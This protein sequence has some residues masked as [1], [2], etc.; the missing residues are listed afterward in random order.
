MDSDS[1]SSHVS[2]EVIQEM[3]ADLG[4]DTPLFNLET[5]QSNRSCM[6]KAVNDLKSLKTVMES[7]LNDDFNINNINCICDNIVRCYNYVGLTQIDSLQPIRLWLTDTFYRI[8]HELLFK[9]TCKSFNLDSGKSD[10]KFSE[11]GIDS[12]RTPDLII[13]LDDKSLLVLEVSATSNYDK[14]AQNK[15]VEEAGF[16]SKYI[17]ELNKLKSNGKVVH[18]VPLIFDMSE[19]T[20]Y[21]EPQLKKLKEL[22]KLNL[23]ALATTRV[24]YHELAVITN[25]TKELNYLPSAILFSNTLEIK[26]DHDRLKFLY[27]NDIDDRELHEYIENKISH[28]VYKRISNLW[29]R[30]PNIIDQAELDY[31]VRY[32]PVLSISNGRLNFKESDK[33]L[34]TIEFKDIL[35][36]NDKPSFFSALKLDTG[37]AIIP[38]DTSTTGF[39]MTTRVKR[40]AMSTLKK[41][42]FSELK[43]GVD[44]TASSVPSSSQEVELSFL[45]KYRHKLDTYNSYI[46]NPKMLEH[47]YEDLLFEKIKSADY[48]YLKDKDLSK[49][50]YNIEIKSD[51]IYNK[52]LK[53]VDI[54]SCMQDVINNML[55][56]NEVT[57]QLPIKRFRVKPAFLLPL[58]EVNGNSYCELSFKNT[59][60]INNIINFLYS[61]DLFTTEILRRSLGSNYH[62]YKPKSSPSQHL[63]NLMAQRAKLNMEICRIYRVGVRSLTSKEERRSYKVTNDPTFPKVRGELSDLDKRIRILKKEEGVTE[64][65]S[66]IRLP[67][68]NRKTEV[69]GWFNNEMSHFKRKDMQSTIEGVGFSSSMSKM[70]EDGRETLN[71]IM[72]YL[73]EY[74]GENKDLVYLD[75]SQAADVPLLMQLKQHAHD[76][77]K[78]LINNVKDS[79]LGHAAALVSRMCHSLLFYSQLNFNAD[80]VRVDNLGYNNV[81]L[82][83]RGGNKIFKSKSSKLYRII[84]PVNKSVVPWMTG[85]GSTFQLFEYLGNNYIVTPWQLMHESI[86]TDGLSFY[87]RVV[88]FTVLNSK[89][90]LLLSEQFTR[91]AV[92]VLLS[93]HNRR[94]TEVFLANLRYVLFSCLGD[95]SGMVAIFNEF[96]GFNYDYF[97]G[98]LRSAFCLN[99]PIYFNQLR[100]IMD[101]KQ[102]RNITV[103]DLIFSNRIKNIF[104]NSNISS[105]DDMALMVYSTFLMTKAPYKRNV[106]RAGNLTGILD[107]HGYYDKEIGLTLNSVEQFNKIS[108]VCNPEDN[109]ETYTSKLFENDFNIDPKYISLMGVYA[110]SMLERKVNTDQISVEWIKIMSEC[111]DSMAT[112]TGLRGDLDDAVDFWGKKGYFVVYKDLIRNYNFLTEIQNLFKLGLTDDEKRKTIRHLNNT[113]LDKVKQKCEFWVFHAV[114]KTQ[115]RGGREIYVMDIHT[116]Q[117][118]QPIEKFMAYLCKLLDN[119]LISIPADKRSQVIHHSI[120]EKDVSLEGC[121]TWYLTLDCS[122]WAP[123]SSFVKFAIMILSMKTIPSSFKTHFLNYLDK[124]YVK[125]IYFNESEVDVLYKNNKYTALI[126]KYLIHDNN[127]KGYYMIMP[128]S[129][130]MGI[131]NYTS[132]FMHAVNQEYASYFITNSSMSNLQEETS[133]T[134]YAH[135][136]DSGGR[137]TAQYECLIK[138]ALF[139]YELQLKCCNHLLS[140]KKSVISRFY[141]EILSIIYIFKQLLAL[142]PKF[143]GGLRFLPT[144]KGPAQDMSQSYSKCIE[145]M[146]AGADFSTAFLVMNFYSA[147]IWRFYYNRAPIQSDF[148]RPVQFLG[149]PCAHPLMVLLSGADSD[150]VRLITSGKSE[151]IKRIL[152]LNNVLKSNMSQD[153]LLPGYKFNIKVRGIQ[154]GFEESLEM[155]SEQLKSWSIKYVNFKNTAFNFLGFLSKLTDPGFVGS[156]VNETTVRRLSRSFYMKSG[157]SVSTAYGNWSMSQLLAA[158]EVVQNHE[159]CDPLGLKDLFKERYEQFENDFYSVDEFAESQFKAIKLVLSGPIKICDYMSSLNLKTENI[160]VSKR[161]LK[162]THLQINKTGVGFS[163]HFDP[164]ILVS[165]ITDVGLRWALPD[166]RS[167]EFLE[168]ELTKLC[169]RFELNIFDLEPSF[170]LQ[171]CRFFSVKNIKDIYLYSRLPSDLKQI[172][173]YTGFLSFLAANSFSGRE[174]KGMV[175]KLDRDIVGADYLAKSIEEQVYNYATIISLLTILTRVMKKD[176]RHLTINPVKE[177]EWSGGTL[178]DFCCDLEN[179]PLIDPDFALLK[180]QNTYLREMLVFGHCRAESLMGC[181][182]YTFIKSQKSG[183][184]WHGQG[185]LY[186]NCPT[187]YFSFILNNNVILS[188]ET[189][190]YGKLD[191]LDLNYVLEV[192][193]SNGVKL[194]ARYFLNP[195]KVNTEEMFGYDWS[196]DIS[197]HKR[198]EMKSGVPAYMRSGRLG[199]M[200]NLSSYNVKFIDKNKYLLENKF[201]E[202]MRSYKIYTLN[203][204]K[205]LL[206]PMIKQMFNPNDFEEYLLMEGFGSLNEFIYN[207]V[208]SDFGTESYITIDTLADNFAST[209]LFSILQTAKNNSLAQIPKKISTTIFPAP[210]GGLLRMLYEYSVFRPDDKIIKLPKEINRDYMSIRSLFPEQFTAVLAETT[211]ANYNKLFSVKERNEI[212]EI[213]KELSQY[214]DMDSL[215]NRLIKTMS[216]WGYTSLTNVVQMYS[217]TK[218]KENFKS[219]KFESNNSYLSYHSE[220]FVVVWKILH[221]VLLEN[222][223]LIN[224]LELPIASLK[225]EKDLT[226]FLDDLN[227]TT[228]LAPYCYHY[229]AQCNTYNYLKF[230]NLLNA[231]LMEDSFVEGVINAFSRE[232][233]LATLPIDHKY[234]Y[235]LV[236][237]LNNLRHSWALNHKMVFELDFTIRTQRLPYEVMEPTTLYKELCVGEA[238]VTKKKPFYGQLDRSVVEF[239]KRDKRLENKDKSYFIK[240]QISKFGDKFPVIE[241]V[242]FKRNINMD[243]MDGNPDFE[244]LVYELEM[245]IL[246]LDTINEYIEMLGDELYH[247]STTFSEKTGNVT[248]VYCRLCVLT[249]FGRIGDL[250]WFN[251]LRQIGENIVIITDLYMPKLGNYFENCYTRVFNSDEIPGSTLSKELIAYGLM[252]KPILNNDLMDALFGKIRLN[253][254]HEVETIIGSNNYLNQDGSVGLFK[255]T[256]EH[257]LSLLKTSDQLREQEEREENEKKEREETKKMKKDYLND[258]KKKSLSST[259]NEAEQTGKINGVTK[260]ILYEK[261]RRAIS[262]ESNRALENILEDLFTEINLNKLQTIAPDLLKGNMSPEESLNV[263]QMPKHW[264]LAFENNKISKSMFSDK[265]VQIELSA[266]HTELPNY[267]G[268]ATL[269]LSKK[270]AKIFYSNFNLWRNSVKYTKHKKG[271]K[272]FLLILMNLIVNDSQL[273]SNNL[274]NTES[275]HDV[276]WRELI[277]NSALYFGDEGD[278]IDNE[279]LMGFFGVG[280]SSRMIYTPTDTLS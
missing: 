174:I 96:V 142:L 245:S 207:E 38:A 29:E 236:A 256:F 260:K 173:T 221:Q 268:S 21:I 230:I 46:Y 25:N 243:A 57:D 18:Y 151:V 172:R 40:P 168:D 128:Y 229:I 164:A 166:I 83:V 249:I 251:R 43:L 215:R 117:A 89:P 264:G 157:D 205:R 129:W 22:L 55:T 7:A 23:A 34:T 17:N 97:Q 180:F 53:D 211:Q 28:P 86:L 88:S 103:A 188:V 14:A 79:Y 121:L 204:G 195:N 64:D 65:I 239:L 32:L 247:K 20:N 248:K 237:M 81:L 209:K 184:S 147:L 233:L 199:F 224:Q 3:K 139:I 212:Y 218:N 80:M 56:T 134:M 176:L 119:E 127:V 162:P 262:H 44:H 220:L 35:Y 276:F 60:F 42:D 11:F 52:K 228:A 5:K 274:D 68:K 19:R 238:T 167:L 213:Y 169:Y 246:D 36:G 231:M 269:T 58:S 141:F 15:G 250:S 241:E 93:F 263:T 159:P 16:E 130:V 24:L 273:V 196:G 47:S 154:K 30:I 100:Q 77:Y 208:L 187:N 84:Y 265:K 41:N 255:D 124:L 192:L 182:F 252:S 102:G 185:E 214:E 45:D 244:D 75:T 197:V 232:V 71:N 190:H 170:L 110:D 70:F 78:N 31:D 108:V 186:I 137:L 6:C 140:K 177:L 91:L 90:N 198:S 153:S 4:D 49:A 178:I 120:F 150:I 136:D 26:Q 1:D 194:D 240:M 2:D 9:A 254:N 227:M 148:D 104:T 216:Y 122:K 160:K 37:N 280:V 219:V 82:I 259:L 179:K 105:Q 149:I 39:K 67:S 118:Q 158:I 33:G 54:Q 270:Y 267:I 63:V 257:N 146:V 74:A 223:H 115:W 235:E 135:S 217:F 242:K 234:R 66:L 161:T 98:Y 73:P 10:V 123:K 275:K 183:S 181:Y 226:S 109:L 144:D 132:S 76:E 12:E 203:V 152:K 85:P 171:V 72:S 175:L 145:V 156:L 87:Q 50:D 210:Q 13:E 106:E 51:M 165:H 189:N 126:D 258:T 222:E 125:R 62:F 59:H 155:F 278:D 201:E 277:D 101:S 193:Q 8:R 112:S 94:Q 200:N 61:T 143:L 272:E 206:L 69:G 99:F 279:E 27:N 111:W 138:R 113:Y 114:D 225:I 116:K 133:I 95:Y 266:L 261:Y 92:N 163:S 131:F 107:I 48:Q 253:P 271:N 202:S 191:Y